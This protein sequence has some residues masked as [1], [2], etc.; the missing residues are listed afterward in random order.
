[1]ELIPAFD[2]QVEVFFEKPVEVMIHPIYLPATN[3]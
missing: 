2:V 3:I 1:M